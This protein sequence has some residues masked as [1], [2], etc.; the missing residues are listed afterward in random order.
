[1]SGI[2]SCCAIGMIFAMS[3]TI[4]WFR[5]V[6]AYAGLNACK[7]TKDVHITG[8][9]GQRGKGQGGRGLGL[10]VEDMDKS[11][12]HICDPSAPPGMKHVYGCLHTRS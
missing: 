7:Q 10:R 8:D 5:E 12:T 1:M 11:S 2:R 6:A 3:W 4:A 9:C